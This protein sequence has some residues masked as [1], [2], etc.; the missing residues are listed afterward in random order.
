MYKLGILGVGKM[1]GSILNGILNASLYDKKDILL[2]DTY[3]PTLEKYSELGFN[4][5]SIV[6]DVLTNSEII[7]LSIKPQSFEEALVNA[8]SYS[9]KNRCI[10]TIAA[11]ISIE[12]LTKYFTDATIIRAMPNTPAQINKGVVTI[13]SNSKNHFFNECKKIF[14]SIGKCYEIDESQMDYTIPLNGS[15]PAYLYAFAKEFIASAVNKGIDY[16]T[17]K[18]LTVESIISSANM[19]LDST[20]PID[21]LIT[22]VCSK[23]GTTIAGLDKMYENNFDKA[24]DDCYNACARRSMELNKK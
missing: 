6:D 16:E 5:T 18:M 10:L 20:D 15:M 21:T 17:A 13:C 14:E 4:T 3:L 1:G 23:G 19:I 9:Y 11:G 22:N 24:I 8:K 2:C 7:L 12:Y